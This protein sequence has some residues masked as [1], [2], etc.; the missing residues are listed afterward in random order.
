MHHPLVCA[1]KEMIM[2]IMTY[3][4]WQILIVFSPALF[5]MWGIWHASTHEFSSPLVRLGWIGVCV[6]LPF[7]GGLIYIIFGRK[8]ALKKI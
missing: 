6:F 5:N 7:I 8:K 1:N 3:E 2:P 4:W